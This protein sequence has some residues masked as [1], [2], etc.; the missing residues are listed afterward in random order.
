MANYPLHPEFITKQRRIALGNRALV[1]I[2]AHLEV[3]SVLQADPGLRAHALDDVLIGSYARK[4]PI[5]PGKDVDVFG[6]LMG[7]SVESIPPDTAY[8]LFGTA[9]QP[10]QDQGRLTPQTRSFKIDYGPRKTPDPTFIR[11]AAREYDWDSDRVGEVLGNLDE[12]A[13]EFSVDVVPAAVWGDHYGIPDTGRDERTGSRYR[14]GSW[15]LTSPVK[16]TELAQA[17]NRDLRVRGI[18]AYVRTVRAV[19]QIKSHWLHKAKPSALYYEFILH[20]G[21]NNGSVRGDCWADVTSNALTYMVQRLSSVA[22]DPVCDPVLDEPYNPAPRQQDVAQALSV[23]EELARRSRR[24]VSTDAPCQ[25]GIEWRYSFGANAR[26]EHVFPLP[27]GCRGTGAA[28]GAAA[29]N[30]STGGTEERSF[31]DF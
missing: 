24:A 25:A 30:V 28:M 29:A 27:D 19:K 4:V 6:R 26:H 18:G 31:G 11:S 9:L 5:W 14:T 16:L 20:E 22:T 7:E 8:G 17:R 3:R 13:F 15:R 21:F 2:A 23:F 1:A 10:F 12:V